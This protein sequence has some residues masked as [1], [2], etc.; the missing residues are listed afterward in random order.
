MPKCHDQS[1][2]VVPK[3]TAIFME[4]KKKK[5]CKAKT[6]LP[7]LSLKALKWF[8]CKLSF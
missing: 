6:T 7:P 3:V 2:L 4:K 5:T 8:V 1:K